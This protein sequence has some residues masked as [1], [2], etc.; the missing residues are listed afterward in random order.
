MPTVAFG[1]GDGAPQHERVREAALAR[2]LVA[3][4]DHLDQV[5]RRVAL[6]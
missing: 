2:A 5:T 1:A 6:G 4:Q 3:E